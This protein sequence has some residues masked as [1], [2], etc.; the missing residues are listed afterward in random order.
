MK[1]LSEL[2]YPPQKITL[3]K[4]QA[5]LDIIWK[6]GEHSQI[7]GDDLRRYCACS[8]CRARQLMGTR[9][10]TESAEVKNLV[11]MGGNA[12]QVVFADGHDR[13]IFPWPYLY[14]IASGRA[15]EYLDE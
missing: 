5:E 6:N 10:I 4:A 8:S 9:L 2:L 11:M 15:K 3:R 12:I 7:S 13:G 1:K 14:A